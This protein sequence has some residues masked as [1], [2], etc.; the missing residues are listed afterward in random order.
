MYIAKQV[1]EEKNKGFI[2]LMVF[3][4]KLLAK[5]RNYV[6]LII[7]GFLLYSIIRSKIP[8][9]LHYTIICT[10]LYGTH[11]KNMRWFYYVY[12]VKFL[13]QTEL[14]KVVKFTTP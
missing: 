9:N 10:L 1:A 2:Y 4:N 14:P 13:L 5:V 8:D 7:L 3:H 12:V 6:S 11:R